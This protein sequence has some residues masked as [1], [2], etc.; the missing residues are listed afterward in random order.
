MTPLVVIREY[1]SAFDARDVEAMVAVAHPEFEAVTPRG[2]MR[3]HAAIRAF[4]ARQ[5]YGV[6]P[7]MEFQRYFRRGDSVV[8]FTRYSW[9]DAETGEAVAGQDEDAAAYTVRDGQV[10]RFE[11]HADLPSALES[12]GMTED[13][14]V[15]GC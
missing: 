7:V 4:M 13:D 15:D 12:A 11:P 10:A 2:V 3:G 14:E 8:V 5:T 1:L 6:T 9:R